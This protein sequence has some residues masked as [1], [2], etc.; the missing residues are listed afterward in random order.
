MS[1]T[2]AV[3]LWLS[4]LSSSG[5]HSANSQKGQQ[6]RGDPVLAARF[7]PIDGIPTGICRETRRSVL[8]SATRAANESARLPNPSTCAMR[9]SLPPASQPALVGAGLARPAGKNRRP[10]TRAA[11]LR[12]CRDCGDAPDRQLAPASIFVDH[13]IVRW[14]NLLGSRTSVEEIRSFHTAT[15]SLIVFAD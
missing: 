9:P 7:E 11:R 6:I 12:S 5:N 8:A 4:G 10:R 13:A 2:E 15:Y 1:A 14:L 3:V